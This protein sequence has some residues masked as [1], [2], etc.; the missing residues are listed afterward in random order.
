MSKKQSMA[1]EQ[2]KKMEG[3]MV[4]A[5]TGVMNSV[6]SKLTELL[7]EEYNLQKG[8]KQDIAFLKDE[9]SS[10]NALLE[11][12]ADMDVLD[13]LTNDW[14]NQVRDMAYDI[15]DC[16]D[17]CMLQLHC[18]SDKPAGIM[19]FFSDM[20]KKVEML[21]THHRMGKQIQELKT[22]IG[23][24]SQRRKRYKIDVVLNSSG[25]SILETIDPR[26]PALYVESSSL[27]GINGP[28]DELIKLV[29]DGE[30]SLK[31]VS[32][33]GLGGVGKT[34][35]ANQ[36]Y[37]K[38]GQQFHCQAF[39]SISQKPDVKN[40]LGNILSQI[41]KG[42][43]QDKN[44]EECWLIDEL[45]AFL[46][47][48]RY[49][50][51]IDDIWSTEAW[52]FIK[53]A[54]PENTCGSRIL[55]TTRNGN[56][57]KICCYPQ[58]G[59]V[60]EIRPLNEADSKGLFFRRIFGSEEQCPVH[61]KDVSVGIINKCG[62]L[63]LALITIASL[64]AVKSKN[65]EEWMGIRN[66][67]GLG[68]QK[69][70]GTDEMTR[71]LYL[72]YTDLPRHLKTCLLY[73]SMYPED[74]VIDVQQL[75]R[76]WRAE[77]FIKEKYGRNLL[78]EG[79]SYLNELI[80]RS[81][82]RPENIGRDGRAKTCR[83][84]DIILDFIVSKAV[85]E[86]FVTFFSDKVLEG[87]ARRLLVDFRGKEI[88]MP[89]LSTA[90]ANANVRSLGIFGYQEEMLHI[91]SHMHALR[92]L[93]IHCSKIFRVEVCDIGK[94]LQLR[95]LRI[96]AIN[97]LPT[98]IVN[99]R[100]LKSLLVHSVRLPDGVGNMQALEELSRVNVD[101]LSIQACCLHRI[102]DWVA[103]ASLTSLTTL[104]ITVQQVTQE[105]IEIL[106]NFPALLYLVIWS[107]GYDT[108]KRLNIYSNRFGCLKTLELDYSPVNLMFHAGA[109][110]K[111]ESIYFL[112]KPNS[113]QSAC[114]HQNLGIRHLL[115]LRCLDVGIDC[116]GVRVEEVEA[117]EAAINNEA[118]LLPD[119]SSKCV[120]RYFS[121]DIGLRISETSASPEHLAT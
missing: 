9:L 53:C 28:T 16:I 77:G 52:K 87:N 85:E 99:L 76:R 6:I 27:V 41:N 45:R 37:I 112:I 54:L 86:N 57:A 115:A 47:D 62:G 18:E 64:L 105:T 56:V 42:L 98:S 81:L 39:V 69:N 109:M 100:R 60:Y 114:D 11:K 5:A 89:M 79:E 88:F 74:R 36:V 113:M 84:H 7:G 116:Q 30:Q 65:W 35:L 92:V 1:T 2:H 95:Y 97:E 4:S 94:L 34:T 13:P 75:V 118:S 68:L 93:N 66:M 107:K 55:L 82:I 120:Y 25:T 17:R 72:S 71:I 15:E 59:T 83:M 58:H 51:I 40:I 90:T 108:A 29:D 20:I 10:M 80:N 73:L 117:L 111:L 46:K 106:G 103:S 23:E 8:V 14:R 101:E 96:E 26:L 61:L 22:R 24:A 102:S 121:D 67:I 19:G 110:P 70:I 33:V 104:A 49:F 44:R 63:P 78:E 119:C 50:V 38:L 12:L 31:V 91:S 43:V 32:I 48:K 21:G 3:I